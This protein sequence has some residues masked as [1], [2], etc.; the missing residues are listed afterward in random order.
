MFPESSRTREKYVIIG[1]YVG[2]SKNSNQH[3]MITSLMLFLWLGLVSDE[4]AISPAP[5]MYSADVMSLSGFGSCAYRH[6]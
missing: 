5:A 2:M 6:R 3:S 1:I 4:E